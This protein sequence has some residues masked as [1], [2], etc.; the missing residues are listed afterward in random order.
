LL[1]SWGITF[2]AIDTEAQPE[3]MKD[4]ARFLIPRV[5]AVIMG[6]R[7]VQG[8]NPKGV[9]ELVGIAYDEDEPLSPEELARQ[10]DKYLVAARRAILQVPPAH[11]GMKTPGRDRTVHQV[12]YHIFR[13]ALSYRDTMEQGYLPEEWFGEK[14]PSKIDDV[15]AI[16]DY[17]EGV[18][19]RLAEWFQRDEA[20]EGEVNTYYGPQTV[21]AFFERT[22]WHVAQHLRQ[23]YAF[24]DLMEV[25]PRN[26]LTEEDFTGLPLPKNVW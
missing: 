19:K 4:L 18:R 15:A 12:G 2:E 21:P 11:L 5:P 14:P 17:G 23:L 20:Y 9:A 25:I 26:P 3:A 10:L 24:L 13:V 7:A 1:S 8:W 6:D 22:V 16:A